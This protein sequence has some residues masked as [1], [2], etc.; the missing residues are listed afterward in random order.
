MSKFL[1]FS[2]KTGS[3]DGVFS[4]FRPIRSM[5]RNLAAKHQRAPAFGQREAGA[6]MAA[7]GR[8]IFRY[9]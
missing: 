3:A 7:Y 6:S 4:L 5:A 1:L 8:L 9:F 2:D